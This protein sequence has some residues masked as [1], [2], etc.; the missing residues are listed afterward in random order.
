MARA[1]V[2]TSPRFHFSPVPYHLHIMIMATATFHRN[3]S[4]FIDIYYFSAAITGLS[5]LYIDLFSI[6]Q[7]LVDG[8]L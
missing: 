4:S 3:Y 5:M 2:N 1:E 7:V 8:E 6:A